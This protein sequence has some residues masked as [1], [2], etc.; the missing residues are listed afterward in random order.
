MAETPMSRSSSRS[1]QFR[2]EPNHTSTLEHNRRSSLSSSAPYSTTTTSNQ[3]PAIPFN[4]NGDFQPPST[5]NNKEQEQEQR[6][7]VKLMSRTVPSRSLSVNVMA[8]TSPSAVMNHPCISTSTFDGWPNLLKQTPSLPLRSSHE[9]QG[10]EEEDDPTST[11]NQPNGVN[12]SISE[13][14]NMSLSSSSKGGGKRQE[15]SEERTKQALDGYLHSP[16]QGVTEDDHQQQILEDYHNHFR[17]QDL[18]RGKTRRRGRRHSLGAPV[19]ILSPL[20]AVSESRSMAASTT[21][22]RRSSDSQQWRQSKQDLDSKVDL[23]DAPP[24]Q[25][26]AFQ[27][28][29]HDD[30]F[31]TVYVSSP[32]TQYF[33]KSISRERSGRRLSSDSLE[34]EHQQRI[35]TQQDNALKGI[36]AP[37][38]IMSPKSPRNSLLVTVGS[39][40]ET[41]GGGS[42]NQL[43]KSPRKSP[44]PG[45]PRSE[46]LLSFLS[47]PRRSNKLVMVSDM[48]DSIRSR[49]TMETTI[50]TYRSNRGGGWDIQEHPPTRNDQGM[51]P[52]HKDFTANTREPDDDDDVLTFEN[53]GEGDHFGTLYVS[54]PS[55]AYF[56]QSISRERSVR[57]LA[58]MDYSQRESRLE[59]SKQ[60][61]TANAY[62]TTPKVPPRRKIGERGSGEDSPKQHDR[63]TSASTTN[64]TTTTTSTTTSIE[65]KIASQDSTAAN[66]NADVSQI[67]VPPNTTERKSSSSSGSS[68]TNRNPRRRHESPRKS[69]KGQP[70]TK[71]DDVR[72]TKPGRRTRSTSLQKAGQSNPTSP[73]RRE[74]KNHRR[75][76]SVSRTVEGQE[77]HVKRKTQR[78]SS[79]SGALDVAQKESVQHKTRRRASMNGA[80]ALKEHSIDRTSRRRSSLDNATGQCVDIA[81]AEH[82]SYGRGNSLS[83]RSHPENQ[84]TSDDFNDSIGLRRERSILMDDRLVQELGVE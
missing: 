84:E 23:F 5:N 26:L 75:Q 73:R 25:I 55:S 22:T 24:D 36:K 12:D 13:D 33:R 71:S 4:F 42:P 2:K 27:S 39:L 53:Q 76:S 7:S 59:E 31:G 6:P 66:A 49:Q 80:I 46:S 29:G 45:F 11:V 19:E 61:S 50:R 78:R 20:A 28:Q 43:M 37:P 47:T 17:E 74:S 70:K 1:R 9:Q 40:H 67:N 79:L 60:D 21:A 63:R 69:R 8:R 82:T 30:H 41:A 35:E 77:G 48:M 58:V 64:T 32:R 34:D 10:K 16:T 72:S 44:R 56:R 62:P 68:S 15:R 52:S 54:S 51:I 3:L 83:R 81:Q 57:G 14:S 38:L 65:S 18:G